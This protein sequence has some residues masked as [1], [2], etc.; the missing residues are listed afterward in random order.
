MAL[1]LFSPLQSLAIW[2]IISGVVVLGFLFLVV[3]FLIRNGKA[4]N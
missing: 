3:R 1:F 4:R 2:P